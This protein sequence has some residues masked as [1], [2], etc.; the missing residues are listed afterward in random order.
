MT[1]KIRVGIQKNHCDL[2]KTI[3]EKDSTIT[4]EIE[5]VVENKGFQPL[6]LCQKPDDNCKD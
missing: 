5:K 6:F 4:Q 1:E 2:R 3:K